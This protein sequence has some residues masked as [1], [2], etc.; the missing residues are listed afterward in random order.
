MDVYG[1]IG[2]DG[3]VRDFYVVVFG[4]ADRF[5]VAQTVVESYGDGRAAV[6]LPDRLILQI[7]VFKYRNT[8]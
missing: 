6:L 4:N 5:A 8:G 7:A 3:V 1:R 2:V